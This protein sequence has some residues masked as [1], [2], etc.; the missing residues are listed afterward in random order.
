[1]D[2]IY[3]AQVPP[4][5]PSYGTVFY[6]EALASFRAG[7]LKRVITAGLRFGTGDIP[8][9][10]FRQTLGLF[11]YLTGRIP[12]MRREANLIVT[13]V[14]HDILATRKLEKADALKVW[15]HAALYTLRRARQM[16]I[17]TVLER[18]SSH[19]LTQ[20]SLLVEEM[21]RHGRNLNT[22]VAPITVKRALAEYEAADYIRVASPF[23]YDSF[24]ENGVPAD[25]L[26]LVPYGTDLTRFRQAVR[27]RTD[28]RFVVVCV[29]SVSWRKG[30]TDLLQAWKIANLPNATLVLAGPVLPEAR[31]EVAAAQIEMADRLDVPGAVSDVPQL[32]ADS[33][34]FVLPTIEEG[35]AISVFEAMA[36]GLP[37]ITTRNSGTVG[38]AD[39]EVKM[40]PIRDPEA[41]AATLIVL[42]RDADMRRALGMAARDL[43]ESFTWANSCAALEAAITSRVGRRH[44]DDT[45]TSI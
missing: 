21:R 42:H 38:R 6:Q 13:G 28:D 31:A 1:M 45:T 34:L 36:V 35:S 37:I 24:I 44:A 18:S 10:K 25:K 32:L 41:L 8:A 26:I 43:S 5:I 22:Y 2:I 29:G 39:K 14:L 3:S 16:G 4:L 23:V 7:S 15:N 11:R 30:V 40:V 27:K 17:V 20:N 12:S 33:D 9:D 19:M